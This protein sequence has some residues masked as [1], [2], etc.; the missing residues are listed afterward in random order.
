MPQSDSWLQEA[1]GVAEE[2]HGRL[3]GLDPSVA[4]LLRYQ[5]DPDSFDTRDRL[6]VEGL[7]DS[8]SRVRDEAPEVLE[9]SETVA[10]A[11]QILKSLASLELPH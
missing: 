8:L 6:V 10:K 9:R 7:Q 11:A 5:A 3:S 2:L 1:A 4:Q